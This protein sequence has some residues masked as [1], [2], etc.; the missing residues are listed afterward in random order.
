MWYLVVFRF[1][2]HRV[3]YDNNKEHNAVKCQSIPNSLKFS[4]A[5]SFSGAVPL[6]NDTAWS[7]KGG[8]GKI[9]ALYD[10]FEYTYVYIIV[11]STSF[12]AR[13]KILVLCS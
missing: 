2:T 3:D 12:F 9:S 1:R 13:L 10:E 4:L 11:R 7:L 5:G 8:L 6:A